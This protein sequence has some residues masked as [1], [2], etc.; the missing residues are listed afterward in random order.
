MELHFTRPNLLNTVLRDAQGTPFYRIETASALRL[1]GKT[2]TV[3]R[4]LDVPKPGSPERVVADNMSDTDILLQRLEEK[5]VGQIVWRRMKQSTLKF[6]GREVLVN[7]HMPLNKTYATRRT[8]TARNGQEYTW[9]FDGDRSTLEKGPPGTS[10]RLS[11]VEYNKRQRGL[12]PGKEPS[13]PWLRIAQE[14]VPILDEVVLTFV[15]IEK[16]RHEK[17]Y[18]GFDGGVNNMIQSIDNW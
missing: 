7:E 11:V 2:T 15:W 9:V 16:R 5:P 8:F 14:I 12:L 1:S 17:Q 3:S 10:P 6:D 18:A 13:Y 4:F